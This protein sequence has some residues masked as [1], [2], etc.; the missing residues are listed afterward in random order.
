MADTSLWTI[1]FRSLAGVDYEIRISGMP[2]A[3]TLTGGMPPLVIDEDDSDD[4]FEPVRTQT[5]ELSLWD[6]TGELWRQVVPAAAGQRKVVLFRIDQ[7]NVRTLVWQ[8]YLAPATYSGSFV[9]E[10]RNRTFSVYCPLQYCEGI[11]LDYDEYGDRGVFE[12]S[13]Y[14]RVAPSVAWYLYTILRQSGGLWSKIYIQTGGAYMEWL[15]VRLNYDVFF[16]EDHK[17][18]YNNLEVL[19]Y[20][21][22]FFGWQLRMHGSDLY[23]LSPVETA[24]RATP[25]EGFTM[26]ELEQIAKYN[27]DPQPAATVSFAGYIDLEDYTGYF[28]NT[29]QLETLRPGWSRCKI[30]SSVERVRDV[31][32]FP[33]QA[34][35]DAARNLPAQGGFALGAG[36][37]YYKNLGMQGDTYEDDNAQLSVLYTNPYF[38]QSIE[39]R[40]YSTNN[41]HSTPPKRNYNWEAPALLIMRATQQTP[42]PLFALRPFLGYGFA[43]GIFVISAVVWD[44]Y[45]TPADTLETNPATG[46]LW[47]KFRVGDKWWDGSAWTSQEAFFSIPT[48]ADDPAT[49]TGR[50][51]ILNTRN[52]NDPYPAFDGYGIPVSGAMSGDVTLTI[53]SIV[54]SSHEGTNLSGVRL[55]NLEVKFLQENSSELYNEDSENVAEVSN[56][57]TFTDEVGFSLPFTAYKDNDFGKAIALLGNAGYCGELHYGQSTNNPNDL[58]ASRIA[59]FGA[60][61]RKCA[62]LELLASRLPEYTPLVTLRAHGD[63]EYYQLARSWNWADDILKIKALETADY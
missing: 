27:L 30:E 21:C 45:F 33:S 17:P 55:N 51:K 1:P 47:A 50:G 42:T 24:T 11:Y 3:R 44:D 18:R 38:H 23:F 25:I 4:F 52:L 54:A 22:I 7:G 20:I 59:A 48:G 61:A 32:G 15:N 16:D 5:G 60:Q 43:N 37:Y 9:P 53:C 62:E 46:I 49:T 13:Y 39:I 6:E 12:N 34:I 63:T 29:S 36:Y 41:P 58:Y 14:G 57:S 35:E 8:G 2:Q 28:A 56:G 31:L 10:R 40:D 26:Q 19:R